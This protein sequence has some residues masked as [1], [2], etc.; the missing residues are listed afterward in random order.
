ML[1]QNNLASFHPFPFMLFQLLCQ[2]KQINVTL[3]QMGVTLLD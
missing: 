3:K 1:I 2:K